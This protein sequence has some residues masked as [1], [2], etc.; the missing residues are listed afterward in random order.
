[1]DRTALML[2]W[3][4]V[5]VAL[6]VVWGP[7]VALSATKPG[8]GYDRPATYTYEQTASGWKRTV[9]SSGQG[10]PLKDAGPASGAG[11]AA[12]AYR[13][14]PYSGSAG[15]YSQSGVFGHPSSAR[16]PAKVSYPVG[17]A[18]L[19]TAVARVAAKYSPLALAGLALYDYLSDSNI[20]DCGDGSSW[21]EAGSSVTSSAASGS[22]NNY[23]GSQSTAYAEV[24]AGF[25]SCSPVHYSSFRPASYGCYAFQSPTTGLLKC[26]NSDAS[27]QESPGQWYTYV[28]ASNRTAKYWPG[29]AEAPGALACPNNNNGFCTWPGELEPIEGS[30]ADKVNTMQPLLA[31]GAA[32][33]FTDVGPELVEL[34]E[35]PQLGDPVVSGPA[36][37]PGNTQT[38]THPDGSQTVTESEYHHT[39]D[40]PTITTTETTTITE[41]DASQTVTSTTTINNTAP[42]GDQSASS[43]T[44]LCDLY[45]DVLA[46]WTAGEVSEPDA[47]PESTI[48][49]DFEPVTVPGSS[50]SCPGPIQFTVQG[51]SFELPWTH[52]CQFA[53]AIKPIMLILAW[54]AAAR[55]VIGAVRGV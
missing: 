34:N 33:N 8:S 21:C 13:A 49:L 36:S 19:A 18:A 9:S 53:S 35:P 55:I 7:R 50:S 11:R 17:A 43:D 41:I 22:E 38:A 16:V 15:A 45:P 28:P 48:E 30:L 25:T 42:P 14:E 31:D 37:T 23:F 20:L 5:A 4:L 54:I 26:Y 47:L 6:A 51:Q 27:R 44:E 1:M 10:T 3:L 46:C 2:Q 40:G 32:D 52:V 29:G 12:G 24:C 39:Y